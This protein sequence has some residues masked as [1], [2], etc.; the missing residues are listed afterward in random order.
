MVSW[1]YG[2]Y[3]DFYQYFSSIVAVNFICGG[4]RSTR[5]KPTDLLQV[6]H[7]VVSSTPRHE[8]DSN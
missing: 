1:F 5:R 7:K 2:G 3:R 4:N 8:R 6:T